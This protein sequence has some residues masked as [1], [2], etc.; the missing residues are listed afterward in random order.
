VELE[1]LIT[2]AT[3]EGVE[4]K[5]RLAGLGSRFIAGV[6]DIMIMAILT[7]ILVVLTGGL[8]ASN[9][10]AEALFIIGVFAIWL[11][12]PIFFE[13]LARGR[14]PGK[15]WTHL[16]VVR[17][18]GSPVDLPASAIRNLM[19]LIDGPLLLYIPT[20]VGIAVTKHNQSPGDVAAG[21]LVIRDGPTA[22]AAGPRAPGV[23]G[24]APAPEPARDPGWDVS[25]VTA[26]ELAVVRR[27]L[28]RRDGL[29]A[30]ARE[31]L[32]QRL[33]HGL[34]AKVAGAPSGLGAESFLE[35][36]AE[37]KASRR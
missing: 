13:V 33:S 9:G 15:R 28:E 19:R 20:V 14:T 30:A 8:G 35:Q 5:L 22:T 21:T 37:I 2:I 10:F 11:L 4:L 34:R 17:D 24:S 27:F 1:D 18:D 25:A 36:L 6:A 32:A 3:P 31:Q 23:T 7:V 26:E 16:R 29:D 12:Y